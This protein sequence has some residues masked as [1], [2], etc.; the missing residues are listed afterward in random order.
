MAKDRKKLQHIHSS[1]PD[2][3]P[4]PATL[5]VGEIAVNNAKDQ[6]FLSIKNSEDKVVRFSSDEQIVTIM[7]RKEVM[8]YEGYVRG[9]DGP[10][11]ATG[12]SS[13][14]NNDLLQNKSNIIIKLNQ[15]AADN[16][17]KHDVV[18]GAEDIYG[19]LVNP[20]ADS[21]LTDG[22]G[23]AIDMSRY[24]MIDANPSFSSLTVTVQTDL[25]GNTTISNGAGT[26]EY[27]TDTGHTLTI[28]TTDVVANDTNWTE[29]ITN[30]VEN[31]TNNTTTIGTNVETI[32]G[33]TTLTVSGTTTETKKGNV[34]ETNLADKQESTS[35]N[36]YNDVKVNYSGTTG[37]TTTEVKVGNVTEN[38]SGTTTIDR[39]GDVSENNQGNV[40]VVT[41]GNNTTT[42]SGNVVSNTS[43]ITT[44]N[45]LGDV[46]E[47]TTGNVVTNTTG[48][49]TEL[50]IGDVTENTSGT[51]TIDRK[52]DVSENNQ[53]NVTNV[54][55]GNTTETIGGKWDVTVTSSSGTEITSCSAVTINTNVFKV[56]Q[57]D[58]EDGSAEFDF[59][60]SYKVNSDNI[61]LLECTPDGKITI[62]EKEG[63]F[64]GETLS[65]YT[66]GNTIIHAE[67]NVGITAK[68]DIIAVS[69]ESNITITADN[70]ICETAGNKATFYGV[71]QTN[72]GLNCSDSAS[73]TT[74]NLYGN[75][76][77][78]SAST[79]NTYITDAETLIGTNNTTISGN[80]TLNVSG[81]TTENKKG[82]VIENNQANKTENTTGNV[83]TN[84]TGTTT[85]VKIG[86]V[87][88]NHSGTT[89]EN[90]KGDVTENNLANKTENTTGNFVGN[91]TGTT[92]E[93][94]Y[95]DVVE[96][97]G[98]KTTENKT[99][100]VIENNFANKTENTTNNSVINIGGNYSGNT[101]GNV[102]TNTTGT[103]TETKVGNVT[104]NHSGTTT[105]NKKGDV[106][107]NNLA[108]KT[109]NTT[110][111]FVGNITGT[112]TEIKIGNVVESHSG[113]TTETKK[114][115]VTETNEANK[116]ENTYMNST[117]N[118][119]GNYSGIT[120]GTTTETKVGNVTENHSG[121]TTE[122]KNGNVIENNLANKTENTTGNVNNNT[123]G[124]TTESLSDKWTVNVTGGTELN[125]CDF[126]HVNTNDYQLK[127]CEGEEGTAEFDF[128]GGF[129]INSD[130]IKLQQC[131]SDGKI[132]IIEKDSIL[133]G[134]NLTIVESGNT[135][136]DTS[137]NTTIN[138]GGNKVDNTT[139][140]TTVNIGGNY[141]GNTTGTTTETKVGNVTENHS[142]TTTENKKGDV[143]E[144]NLANKTE[145]TTGNVVENTTGTTTIDRTGAVS[146][147]NRNNVTVVTSGNSS[148]TVSGNVTTNTSGTTTE[149]K[150]GNVTENNLA[151]K[152]ENTTGTVSN[153]T[154]GT[155]T[156]NLGSK[157][158]INVTA[159]TELNSCDFVHVSTN[160][161]QLKQCDGSAG[162]AEFEF[163]SGYT[164]DSDKI[165]LQ[166][167]GSNG[168]I[169]IKE[170]TINASGDTVNVTGG[171]SVIINAPQTHITGNTYLS[172]TTYI[173]DQCSQLS[174]TTIATSFCEVFDRSK[175]TMT[176][177]DD[178][179]DTRLSAIYRLWQDGSQ[180]GY[181]INVPKDGFLKDVELVDVSGVYNLRFTWWIYDAD[182]ATYRT[183]TT[184]VSVEDLVKEIEANNTNTDRGANV[185]VWYNTTTKKM[186]V[187]ATTKITINSANGDK[188]FARANGEHTLSSYKLT[189]TAGSFS[190]KEFD[191]FKENVT[192]NVPTD[193]SHISRKTLKVTHNGFSDTYDPGSTNEDW[194]LPH[195]TLT[196]TYE[197]TSGKSGS[198]TYNTG[199][200]AS[201]SIPTS[202]SHLNRGKFTVTHN[203]GTVTFDPSTDTSFTAPHSALT[204]TYGATSGKSG[205][206]TFNTSAAASAAIP[207]CVSH[208]DRRTL[209]WTLGVPSAGTYDPGNSACSGTDEIKIPD[210]LSA[211]TDW[212]ADCLTINNDLCVTGRVTTTGGVFSTSD[213]RVKEDI[214]YVSL[215]YMRKAKN[216]P[217]K[218][219]IFKNDPSKRR[220][221][222]IIAQ[223]AEAAGFNELVHTDEQGMKTV[224]YTS[225]LIARIAQL[226]NTLAILNGKIA[227]LEGKIQ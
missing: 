107:E 210:A 115:D 28:E 114:G 206:V 27:G 179:A 3:Q 16:T 84:T 62:V 101:S 69:S 223:D 158:T 81:A 208:L 141:T 102:V 203:G 123:T 60:D 54:T 64:S 181:D 216:I 66:S 205:S 110:G 111:N 19:N 4:T 138:T 212:S 45:K 13:V 219:F 35:G 29:T 157:W 214:R 167:C 134:E 227:E 71:E 119:G 136:I 80:T 2:K 156:E 169:T 189:T 192:I 176:R 202:I 198:V 11:G 31:I 22:A 67:E 12:T 213:E 50:K 135:S 49:T 82:N 51:T 26:N 37:G 57:C 224:D 99:G 85:E 211:L 132:T 174:S 108:N 128:C 144:N 143:V 1:V 40:T 106:T 56:Q 121:T 146:E 18:N 97:H 177:V 68:G 153:N 218:S 173:G 93:T 120:Q 103:T 142:G 217:L 160:D 185:D 72:L 172:G 36:S 149:N 196:A 178:P 137:G 20:T 161:Y 24:A 130:D 117:V 197:A 139:G 47:N 88:E 131:T 194:T 170:K 65:S 15:V 48:T 129:T 182:T 147:N 10:T 164:V 8:P 109:E 148:T 171:T 5:E 126:V 220:V 39:K 124:T 207:T 77:V 190:A 116:V 86:N 191:P 25:S 104:E 95:G 175:V 23:F 74:T 30:K 180:I 163:C 79:A 151:N 118:V 33:N 59:C 94:K 70:D 215:D 187:S 152:T 73:S 100:D 127:Q 184:D 168:D 91:T 78:T 76:L 43:G 63:Y 193:A 226:E 199:A 125:S 75:T 46:T 58:G 53:S 42:I 195:S 87:T 221:F 209:K 183:G 159:G 140:N 150:K 225:F 201:I 105:E 17:V 162:K 98:G 145:N 34:T 83:V 41:S 90:K 96:N 165:L 188:V 21:G 122:N 6:E 113:T 112:T 204:L 92:T 32:S 9:E 155:T 89:T 14:T 52:G 186:N 166:Q 154:T 44:E 7:E 38:T 222:G 200:D 133:S 55:S 61:E